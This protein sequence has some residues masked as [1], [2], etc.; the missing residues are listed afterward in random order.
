MAVDPGLASDVAEA[1][2]QL[3]ADRWVADRDDG[4]FGLA[5]PRGK[6]QLEVEAGIIRI[7]TGRATTGGVFARRTDREGIFV[8]SKATERVLETWAIDRSY[9]MFDA[10]EVRQIRLDRGGGNPLT[11]EPVRAGGSDAGPAAER[12]EI[13]RRVL[14]EARA[15]GTVH[16]GQAR[17]NEGFDEPLLTV[18][19]QRPAPASPVKIAIGKGDAW[20]ETTVFYVRREGVDATFAVAQ[21]KVRPLLDLK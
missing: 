12:F 14:V 3:R 6:Y 15:E 1:L 21:S 5:A 19:I 8:L 9:L 18:T 17:N 20:R 10:D 2:A 4:S 7:E 16:L 13:A 11:L